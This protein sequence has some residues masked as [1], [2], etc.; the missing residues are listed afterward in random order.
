MFFVGILLAIIAVLA[1]VVGVLGW[2][3]KL[4]GNSFIGIKVPEVRKSRQMWDAAHQTAGPLWVIG[5]VAF[6]FAAML[7]F[8]DNAWLWLT[9]A[10]MTLFGVVLVALGASLGS[11]TVA[12]LAAHDAEV[13]ASNASCCS[14]G[15]AED[16]APAVDVDALR[17][18]VK[19]H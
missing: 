10:V 7:C 6:T 11:R 5:G 2:T 14:A 18:A 19:D 9:A 17:R 1:I 3:R 15:G 12:V 16:E 4:P 8:T 13:E